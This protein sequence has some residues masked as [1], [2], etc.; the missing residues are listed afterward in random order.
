MPPLP[1]ARP[2]FSPVSPAAEAA[3]GDHM[4]SRRPRRWELDALRGLMLVM[5]LSTH[6]PTW[7]AIPSGQPLGFVSAAEGFVML[8]AYMA[9]LVYTQR[10]MHAG[11]PAMRRAFLRRAIVI[12]AC[13]AASLLFLFT[14]I[15]ALGLEFQH[16]AASNLMSFYLKEP[17]TALWAG[18]LLIYNPPLLD[19][20]PLY[21]MFMLLSPWV[22]G[23]ALRKGWRVAMTASVLLWAAAQ[24]G[25]S[26]FLYGALV[27]A[28]G[29]T[30]P[31][32]E[33][34]SF[35]TF[36]WQFLWMFGLWLGS[37][38]ARRGS[39]APA[40]LPGKLVAAA[41]GIGA[42]FF[43]WRHVTGQEPFALGHPLNA[44][45]DKW[46]LG[47]MRLL[48]FA[49]LLVL[50]MRFGPWLKTWLP[51]IPALETMGA[52]SLQVFCTHLVIVLLALALL[53]ESTPARPA[54][55]DL[56]LFAVSLAAL[57]MAACAFARFEPRTGQRRASLPPAANADHFI[58]RAQE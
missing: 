50:G 48:D 8:S 38:H 31:F 26:Q 51:R 53:G 30:V 12:Y 22:L 28:T 3:A 52:V 54:W 34:G 16:P 24:F 23:H 18:L 25:L 13:Q 36:A 32:R 43:V 33:T 20:L 45:F 55:V 2:V 56:A 40:P 7:F 17:L 39:G 10:A 5:M 19:I 58:E 44:F 57:W 11:I 49:A 27:Q 46:H 15:A 4:L 9:G 37:S 29:L 21:V 1:I 41:I 6:L 47:P 42:L 14:V 35:E